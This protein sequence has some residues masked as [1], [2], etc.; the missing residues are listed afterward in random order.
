MNYTVSFIFLALILLSACQ[1]PKP[2]KTEQPLPLAKDTVVTEV[3]PAEASKDTTR[4]GKTYVGMSL[5]KLRQVYKDLEF[6]KEPLF[7]YGVD[8]D[9]KGW[10]LKKDH[11]PFLFVWTQEGSENIHSITILSDEITVDGNVYVGMSMGDYFKK[12]PKAK[13]GIDAISY[14]IEFAYVENAQ[15]RVECLT[16]DSSRIGV[17]NMNE[18]EPEFIKLLKPE[19]KIERITV[20]QQ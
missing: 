16:T 4:V 11:K 5:A 12:Y 3:A 1:S 14:D 8:S 20:F 7:M 2:S 15:Y 19:A 18:P 17:Y 13:L 6:V 10:L 9:E